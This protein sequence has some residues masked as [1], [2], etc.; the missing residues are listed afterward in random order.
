[1]S[2]KS[3]VWAILIFLS[4]GIS[5]TFF[6]CRPEQGNSFRRIFIFESYD[7]AENSME[8]RYLKKNNGEEAIREFVEELVLGPMSD[9]YIRLFPY[10]TKVLSCFIR[11]NVLY[12]DLSEEAAFTN[13]NA[14]ETKKACMLLEEN[15]RQN[16][17]G[18]TDYKVFMMGNEVY[19]KG[20]SFEV[21]N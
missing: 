17:S 8:I 7:T 3:I 20:T 1:M 16:F 5:L 13:G 15:I 21:D 9:R 18:L 4:A 11:D 6:L 10:G 14:T 12:T 2:K 19:A